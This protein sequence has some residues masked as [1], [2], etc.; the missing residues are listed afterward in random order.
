YSLECRL[1]RADGVYR[2]WLIRGEPMRGANGDILKW[3]GTCTDIEDL[4]STE[5][6]LHEANERLEQSV[7]ERTTELFESE[8][9]FRVLIQNLQ[10][11]VALV[12][13]SGEFTIVNRAFL[14][15]FELNDDSNVKNVNDRDWSQWQVFDEYGSLLD[16]DEHPVRQAALTGRPVQ[17]K[18]VA[19][20]APENPEIKWLL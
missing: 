10:S 20:K 5:A 18:L 17:D 1:R 19:V 7:T 3:F 12:N 9:Q 14:R 8:H 2:W 6:V 15:L 16:V 13:E 11:A 4:K